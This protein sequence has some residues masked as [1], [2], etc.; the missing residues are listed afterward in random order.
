MQSFL[1]ETAIWAWA[2]IQHV[3]LMSYWFWIP[4]SLI[5]A[6]LS[7]HYRPVF[8][9]ATL[10]HRN[11]AGAYWAAI[12]WGMTS[13]AGRR[14]SLELAQSLW[15]QGLP[16][17]IV[18]AYLVTSQS[19]GLYS[20]LLFTVLIGLE[21]GLGLFLGEVVMIVLLHFFTSAL[22]ERGGFQPDHASEVAA[23]PP[24]HEKWTDLLGSAMGWGQAVRDVGR[25]VRNMRLSLGGGL[26]L[27]A[28]VLTIDNRGYWLFP[29]WMG[30]ETLGSAL[31]G[32][33]LAPLLSAGSLL[34]PG[35]NLIVASSIWKTWTLTYSGVLS[36]VLACPL[37]PL[38]LRI[39]IRHYGRRRGW[40]LAL[41]VYLCAA[42]SGLAVAGLF[43][44]LGVQVTHVPW[45]RDLV[46]TLMMLFPFTMLGAPGEG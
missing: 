2:Y 27:G 46:D 23:S 17:Q 19:L 12:G 38:T 21:F 7:A 6:F 30:D 16:D 8:K 9:L 18:L 22:A 40:Q 14:Q 29:K 37:N 11:G 34:A 20:L 26:L 25:Y 41:S 24:P 36:L 5:V 42:L 13:G 1:W 43:W 44:L 35:G 28:L 32:S 3:V 33:F 39:L 4:A 15:S 31:A 10:Q 45:F